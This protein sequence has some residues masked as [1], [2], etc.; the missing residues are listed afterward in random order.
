MSLRLMT[1]IPA[2]VIQVLKDYLPGEMAAIATTENDGI[3]PPDIDDADYYEWDAQMIPRYPAISLRTVSSQ[4]APGRGIGVRQTSDN[5]SGRADVT[6]R[7][8]VLVHSTT[9]KA[10]TDPRVLQSHFHRYVDGV[11]NVLCFRKWGLQTIA[12]PVMFGSPNATTVCEWFDT[13]TY[14]PSEA[15]EDGSVVR[16]AVLPLSIRRIEAR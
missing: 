4:P 11:A 8:D 6:H 2:R 9:E 15:Q 3:T 5:E 14:G 1:P 12:D 16:T 7:V 13:A 10:G